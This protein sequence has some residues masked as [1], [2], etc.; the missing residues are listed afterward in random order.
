MVRPKWALTVGILMMLFGGCGVANDI[1]QIALPEVM[2]FQNDLVAELATKDGDEVDAANFEFLEK[3]SGLEEDE[4]SGKNLTVVDHIKHVSNI[5]EREMDKLV[6]HGYV[7]IVISIL[8]VLA[9][10]LLILKRKHILKLVFC[11]LFASIVFA[12]FQII[13]FRSFN[14]SGLL[15]V[16]LDFNIYFGMLQDIIL[17]IVL[18]IVDKT[19]Y[20]EHN[21]FGDYYDEVELK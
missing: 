1:K 2:E 3:I 20:R 10:I 9:G 4:E 17:V 14:I 16:G 11:I 18:L 15:K 8:Y 19:Y 7:G 5:P 21:N 12:I 13:E 6:L